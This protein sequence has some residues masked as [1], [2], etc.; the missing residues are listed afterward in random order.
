MTGKE[1]NP[2]VSGRSSAYR[3]L[4]VLLSVFLWIAAQTNTTHLIYCDGKE[5]GGWFSGFF[6]LLFSPMLLVSGWVVGLGQIPW[7]ISL[8]RIWRNESAGAASLAMFLFWLAGLHE[9]LRPWLGGGFQHV[10]GVGLGWVLM[11]SAF[12][13]PAATTALDLTRKARQR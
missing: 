11:S 1:G 13:V 3:K 7:A 12:L 5:L 6:T 8:L 4:A 9:L 10:C 2:P